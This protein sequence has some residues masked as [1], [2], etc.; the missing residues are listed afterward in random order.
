[1]DMKIKMLILYAVTTEDGGSMFLRDVGT[2]LQAQTALQPRR[3]TAQ[4]AAMLA[5]FGAAS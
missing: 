4:E 3:P 1:M 5:C 2:R